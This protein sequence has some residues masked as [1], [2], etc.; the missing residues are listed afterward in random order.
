M[1]EFSEVEVEKVDSALWSR[2]H[3]RVS[4]ANAKF[5]AMLEAMEVGDV[6]R[7]PDYRAEVHRLRRKLQ[8]FNEERRAR[9]EAAYVLPTQR[10]EAEDGKEYLLIRRSA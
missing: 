8:T 2:H 6:L 9:G 5:Y 10:W 1:T 3:A 4:L 7:C